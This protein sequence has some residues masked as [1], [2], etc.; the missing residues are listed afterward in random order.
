MNENIV[1][2]INEIQKNCNSLKQAPVLHFR[3]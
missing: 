3:A 2:E 1:D